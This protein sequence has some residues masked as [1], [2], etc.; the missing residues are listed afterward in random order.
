[1][2]SLLCPSVF[3]VSSVFCHSVQPHYTVYTRAYRSATQS[4]IYTAL[5]RLALRFQNSKHYALTS[6]AWATIISFLGF[7]KITRVFKFE[8]IRSKLSRASSPLRRFALSYHTNHLL[9]HLVL[10]FIQIWISL[11][12]SVSISPSY[13]HIFVSLIF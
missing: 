9:W 10:D 3:C 4:L 7:S 8:N 5:L 11:C 13:S 12:V 2:K 6:T 1:M